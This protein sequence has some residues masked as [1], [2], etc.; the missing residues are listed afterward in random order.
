M[1]SHKQDFGRC[2]AA[3]AGERQ[4][5]EG[6]PDGQR[7]FVTGHTTSKN[8]IVGVTLAYDGGASVVAVSPDGTAVFVT[9]LAQDPLNQP[10][11]YTTT[12]YSPDPPT[13]R[14]AVSGLA[15]G[16]RGPA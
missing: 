14:A 3:R 8:G 12:A 6:S 11:S 9:G 10:S 16:G 15:S 13:G 4:R 1:A 5:R 7:V 2:G